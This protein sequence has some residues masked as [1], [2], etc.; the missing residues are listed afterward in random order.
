MSILE[1]LRSGLIV[2]CQASPT[3]PLRDSGIMAAMARAALAGGA[4]GI[5]A[6]GPEDIRAIRA[7][8]HLPILGIYKQVVPGFDV[9]ITP[10]L[11]TAEEVAE[12]GSDILA[13]D[14]TLRPHPSSLTPQEFIKACKRSFGLPV[15]ADISTLEEALAAADAG[16]DLVATTLVGYTPYTSHRPQPDFELIHQLVEQAPVPTIVEG[17]IYSPEQA[18]RALEEGAFAIVVGTAIT[19]PDWI[20]A[21][22]VESLKT[23]SSSEEPGD[24]EVIRTI[25]VD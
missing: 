11:E 22:Y 25:K 9:Y 13:V 19:Q 21:R 2:S 24:Q 17:H 14:A 5:R 3:S 23:L 7:A 18:R 8:V 15:M 16:A 10:T 1:R 20:T 12:A 4:A 6:N